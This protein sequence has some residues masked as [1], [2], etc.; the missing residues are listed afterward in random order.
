MRHC[1]APVRAE[2]IDAHALLLNR[3]AHPGTWWTGVERVAIAAATRSARACSFCQE[4][5]AALS[6]YAMAGDHLVSSEYSEVLPASVIDIVHLATIDAPRMTAAAINALSDQ[7]L[8]DAHYVEALGIAVAV[9]SIDQT[10]RALGAPLHQLPTPV[11]GE[12]SR[13]RPD[14]EPAGEAFVPM[15]AARQPAPPNDDLWDENSI[16]YGLRAMSLV[17]DAVRDLRILSAAQ[18]IP[19]DK[20]ADFS[21]GRSLGR[22]Q[23]ELLATRVAVI[24]ECFY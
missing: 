16:Y 1:S 6:P 13:T 17:P 21:H 8:S 7:G 15:L 2:L 22:E 5:K 4:R 3:I 19:L 14:V 10:C 11:P 18:Y 9:R 20:A 24:N 23:M 12:P